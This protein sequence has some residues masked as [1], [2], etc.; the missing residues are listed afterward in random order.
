[1]IKYFSLLL[2]F[3]TESAIGNGKLFYN[4][5]GEITIEELATHYQV[6]DIDIHHNIFVGH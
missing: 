1:M 5:A 4:N 2:F 3:V 6:G